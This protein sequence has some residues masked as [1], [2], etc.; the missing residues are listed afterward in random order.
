MQEPQPSWPPP[1]SPEESRASGKFKGAQDPQFLR[2]LKFS[3]FGGFYGGLS[4]MMFGAVIHCMPPSI[5]DGSI[6][7]VSRPDFISFGLIFALVGLVIGSVS[8]AIC[9][10][11][12]RRRLAWIVIGGLFSISLPMVFGNLIVFADM[13]LMHWPPPWWFT[14]ALLGLGACAGGFAA[15]DCRREQSVIP[16]MGWLRQFTT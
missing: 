12:F 5:I 8:G 7:S 2:I 15:Y 3:V 10:L 9:G 13:E 14:A 11:T 16:L 1:V 6:S 4:S